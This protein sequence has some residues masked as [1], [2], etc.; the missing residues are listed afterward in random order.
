MKKNEKINLDTCRFIAALLVVAIHIYPFLNINPDLDYLVTRVLFRVAVPL[1]LMITGYFVIPKSLK[2]IDFLKVYTK[3]IIKIYIICILIYL[4]INIYNGDFNNVNILEILKRIFI[5]GTFY[6]LWYFPA[7]ILGIWITYFIIKKLDNKKALIIFILLYLV[8]LFGDSYYGLISSTF[9]KNIYDVIFTVTS[10]TRNGLFYVPLFIFIGYTFKNIT[11][12]I[13]KKQNIILLIISIILMLIEG[14]ILYTFDLQRH[15]SMYIFLIP[16]MFLIFNLLV[17]NREYKNKKL[18]EL[19]TI[20]YVLHPLVIII[21]RS[22]AKVLKLESILIGNNL[23]HY[24]CVVILTL[25]ISIVFIKIKEVINNESGK[26][27]R[28]DIIN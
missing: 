27:K 1:F 9:L 18:R 24:I 21:V 11:Y 8:G 7:L 25:I 6:H 15:S 10:Y 26:R 3:K 16:V 22:I 2:Y 17:E 13:T 20:I 5:D 28:R 4:P 23:I 12:R 14:F 19:S